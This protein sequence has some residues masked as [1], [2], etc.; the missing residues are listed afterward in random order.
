[1]PSPNNH[2]QRVTWVLLP[3]EVSQNPLQL[4][5]SVFVGPALTVSSA[6]AKPTLAD[7]PDWLDWPATLSRA[8][9][10]V[11]ITIEG[12]GS[13]TTE[14]TVL[15]GQ[16]SS[17]LW[18]QLF[19]ASTAV[20]PFDGPDDLTSRPVLTFTAGEVMETLRRSYGQTVLDAVDDL[21]V[22][23]PPAQTLA[24]GTPQPF[25][26]VFAAVRDP[27]HQFLLTADETVFATGL[28]A[29][30]A[31]ARTRNDGSAM[32]E[33]LPGGGGPAAE[34]G[35]A[36]AFHRGPA[37]VPPP[38]DAAA[39]RASAQEA[40][41]RSA[42]F[43]AILASMVEHP[44]LLRRLGLVF[45]VAVPIGSA[46][47]AHGVAA[48]VPGWQPRLPG[49][50]VAGGADPG[51]VDRPLVVSWR[52]DPD[53]TLPFAASSDEPPGIVD[54][55]S[56]SDYHVQPVALDSAAL[57]AVS[58]AIT[59]GDAGQHTA[60]PALRSQGLMLVHDGHAESTYAELAAAVEGHGTRADDP[61]GADELVRGYRLDV[62]D[63][64]RGQ[65]F[66]LHK[67]TVDYLRNGSSVLG[68]VKDEGAFHP[69]VTGP[70][71]EPGT[72][73]E[74]H[75]PMRI[76]EGFLQWDGWSLSAPRPGRTLSNTTNPADLTHPG[77]LTE[78]P[79]GGPLTSTGLQ[80]Q[81]SARPG[82]LPRLRFGRSYRLRLRTVDLAGNGL[83]LKEADELWSRPALQGGT[84]GGT[85]RNPREFSTDPVIFSRYEPV[86]PPAIVKATPGPESA[87][88]LVVRSGLDADVAGLA[89]STDHD[90]LQLFAPKASVEL[91][92]RHGL[93]DDAIGS[94]DQ[95]KVRASFQ[96]AS[97][98]G[99]TLPEQG[100]NEIPYLPDPLAAGIAIADA[101]GMP[102]GITFL[103]RWKSTTWHDPAPVT[104]RLLVNDE[105][106]QP[107]PDVDD[108][109]RTITIKLDA[110][111]RHR[112]RIASMLPPGPAAGE[113]PTEL[114]LVAWAAERSADDQHLRQ[115]KR[116]VTT[117]R[118]CMFTPWHEVELVHAV[119]RPRQ[120]PDLQKESEIIR[121]PGET[122]LQT[123]ATLVP[124]PFST[125]TLTLAAGWT[126]FVDDPAVPMPAPA[127]GQP[128]PWTRQVNTVV[129]STAFAE[130]ELTGG[131][132]PVFGRTE[133]YFQGSTI[134]RLELGDTKHRK[135]RFT[136]TAATRFAEYFPD[137]L[138][139][140][141]GR[142]TRTGAP[143]DYIALNTGRP[144]APV[145]L[146]VVPLLRRKEELADGHLEQVSEGGWLRIW[147]ARPWFVTGEEERLG[148][149]VGTNAPEG[150]LISWYDLVSLLGTDEAH[151]SP[152]TTI[153]LRAENC[154]N[155]VQVESVMVQELA[156]T[157][158]SSMEL[159]VVAFDPKFDAGQQLW[160]ADI[161]IEA[162]DVYFPLVRLALVRYQFHS[163]PGEGAGEAREKYSVSP[164][165]LTEPVPLLPERRLR[166]I[167]P[168]NPDITPLAD[169][170]FGARLAGTTYVLPAPEHAGP[171]PLGPATV[172]A[173]CQRRTSQSV[174]G[175]GDGW[176][177]VKTFDFGRSGDGTWNFSTALTELD[178]IDRILVVE[179][180]HAAY[181]PAVPQPTP[182]AS[183]VVYA[184]VIPG[185]F[186]TTPLATGVP[187]D[188][189]IPVQ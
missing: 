102:E 23:A 89:G 110:A 117:S 178:G 164:V 180:D 63:E 60:P 186:V 123:T 157:P 14:A 47:A 79:G 61:L 149:L 156:G 143:A 92:E 128:P 107:P 40:A 176:V 9:F 142:L 99:G 53:A 45:D 183:R 167:P 155:A 34:I 56:Q 111:R 118:H 147:L 41:H 69:S 66:S 81:T 104:L 151:R 153:G 174:T 162:T 72:A 145:V 62:F 75:P 46:A 122:Q 154:T 119:Q 189:G 15:P 171:L 42:D 1:M 166:A 135:V 152:V 49:P 78:R 172:T 32:I 13:L 8:E 97:R 43:H 24:P 146:D 35:R 129:G 5:F 140:Q 185:P 179:E 94:A 33:V 17:A 113:P 7:Y 165:V 22:I 2:R 126:D 177:T 44:A 36:M 28:S 130:P 52:L 138:A 55:G 80:V 87:C 74:D 11:E 115:V 93:L 77:T 65:W 68:P 148:L 29:L 20:V 86:S 158:A 132:E 121:H 25:D 27:A 48:L 125:S 133:L 170:T 101:P 139:G 38:G 181:D 120:A 109:S 114:G 124:D 73:A 159:Q 71:A 187:D 103:H 54:I 10:G 173:R 64:E 175:T 136:V 85:P 108:E 84:G 169:Q 100:A 98:E 161:H 88:R 95:A 82:S 127:D 182:L 105:A 184:E 131:V 26:D 51:P 12:A 91:I 21:P 163:V 59:I 168:A 106:S 144:P 37:T 96:L 141:P 16:R 67:R 160:Y 70:Y 39:R 19:P 90:E 50:A 134:P 57:Q 137:S 76:H 150:P 188:P 58:M 18:R 4:V 31:S 3:K 112:I 6:G 116:A 30:V 83:T